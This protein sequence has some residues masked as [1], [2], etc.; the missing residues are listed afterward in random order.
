MREIF[1]SVNEVIY[2]DLPEL[3]YSLRPTKVTYEIHKK[4][5]EGLN[6]YNVYSALTVSS[7]KDHDRSGVWDSAMSYLRYLRFETYDYILYPLG[8]V[9]PYHLLVHDVMEHLCAGIYNILDKVVLYVDKPYVGNRYARECMEAYS[10]FYK[11]YK[12]SA[13]Y[14]NR[15]EVVGD[16]LKK[17]YPT[18]VGML[19]FSS[20]SL[21]ED[22]DI[23]LST[24]LTF[25]EDL[26]DE[27]VV[28]DAI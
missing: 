19:R 17:V 27:T 1:T 24:D 7:T 23:Y 3:D 8:L 20:Q 14:K 4:F 10:K 11:C 15:S 6:V 12:T 28:C 22:P 21:L 5:L 26:F 2:A 9:H 25:K 13:N 18:E 16:A